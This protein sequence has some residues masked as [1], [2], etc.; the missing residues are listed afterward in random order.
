MF[1]SV[2]SRAIRGV[3]VLVLELGCAA[4]VAQQQTYLG[5]DRNDYPGD[6][7][8]STLRQTFSYT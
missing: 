5:F 2:S 4:A 8:L 1:F 3:L 6:A 7:N